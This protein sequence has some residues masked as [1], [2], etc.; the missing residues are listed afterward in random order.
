MAT[1]KALS[2]CL[3]SPYVPKHFGG[4]ER[5][6]FSVVEYL[7]RAHNVTVAIPYKTEITDEDQELI[8]QAYSEFLQFDLANVT[9]VATPLFSSASLIDKLKWTSKFDVM[10][11]LTD[12]SLFFS[13]AKKNILHVQ[14]PF[15]HN[16]NSITDR[17]KLF[18]WRIK[19][20][21]SYFTKNVIERQ[22][23]TDVPF[24]HQ[25][26]VDTELFQPG[27][28]KQ[29]IILHVG[30]FFT[31]LHAKR[32]DML[33][34]VFKKMLKKYPEEMDGWKLVLIGSIEDEEYAKNV[35]D[36]ATGLPIEIIHD[37]DQDEVRRW[38]AKSRIYWHATGYEVEEYLHPEQVEHFGITTLEAMAS[39]CV[40]IVI[41]KGG[42]P[43]IVEHG[44]SGYLWNETEAMIEKTLACIKDDV[45]TKD[46]ALHAR[47][48]A[49]K[50]SPEKFYKKLEKMVDIDPIV[51]HTPDGKVSVVI[52]NY[53][54]RKLLQ[55][56][57]PSV[58]QSMR[59]GDELVIVDDMSSDDSVDWLKEEF[60]LKKVT[61][62][63]D[64]EFELFKS[65][66]EKRG[67]NIF[68][69]VMKNVEN[70]RFAATSNR[71]VRQAR[72]DLIFLINTDVKPHP[73]TIDQLVPHFTKKHSQVF[74]VGCLEIEKEDD[75]EIKGGRNTL[76][77]ERGMFVHSRAERFTSG[78]TGWVSGGSGMFSKRKWLEIGGFDVEYRPAYWEDIDLSYRA[79]QQGWQVLFSD[80][81]VVDHN[82]E[83]T[84]QDAFGQ[85]RMNV[86][87]MKNAILFV[88]KNGNLWEKI[89]FG[90]WLPYHL[91][92]TNKKT[93][94]LFSKGL[95]FLFKQQALEEY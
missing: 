42:Q 12:G 45:D 21:N 50:F 37:A 53:N 4:G 75:K 48:R 15:T 71:G 3:I 82:H 51:E 91:V 62:R 52:P 17:L 41:N 73:D 19:N 85:E 29:K 33:V 16:M 28:R 49:E 56:H 31:Q 13:L 24:V 69:T 30:R 1:K 54:G 66:V 32:Q 74:A 55:R 35:R 93:D 44:V 39:G 68:V 7:S 47:E 90:F 10:Y 88:L 57:L 11:Y 84:N 23:N 43:E 92:K 72:H 86:M 89:Q 40:P 5:Y 95:W 25:P 9:F 20:T 87:S 46:L 2:I 18:N 59:D 76:W 81:A 26:F 94:N 14:V 6:F 77:F 64:I 70:V 83:T 8:R 58:M 80:K 22:W 78:Q 38:F 63:A 60:T 36:A 34:K 79:R 61:D 67:K 27:E 65:E